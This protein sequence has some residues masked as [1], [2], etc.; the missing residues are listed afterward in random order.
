VSFSVAWV[1]AIFRAGLDRLAVLAMLVAAFSG[2]DKSAAIA[3][4][5]EHA[6]ASVFDSYSGCITGSPAHLAL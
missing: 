2:A 6:I 1:A 4:W 3:G 5:M